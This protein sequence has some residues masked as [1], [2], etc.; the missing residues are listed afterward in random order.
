MTFEA[1]EGTYIVF[2][3]D[4]SIMETDWRLPETS[5]VWLGNP[6]VDYVEEI[7]FVAARV[8]V[9]TVGG[10]FE[11][12]EIRRK[13]FEFYEIELREHQR[14]EATRSLGVAMEGR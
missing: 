1:V 7:E 14:F 4:E 6:L 12:P 11:Y 8:G 9:E 10:D 13:W 2:N 3:Q 5:S